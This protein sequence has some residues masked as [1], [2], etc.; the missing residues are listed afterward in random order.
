MGPSV[1]VDRRRGIAL[2]FLLFS[3]GGIWW[4]VLGN[5]EVATDLS[6]SDLLFVALFIVISLGMWQAKE[7]SRWAAGLAGVVSSIR[8]MLMFVSVFVEQAPGSTPPP[9]SWPVFAALLFVLF[10]AGIAV[11][12]LLPST[13]KLFAE[14]RAHAVSR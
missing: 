3:I 5:G 12:C 10:W 9:V 6:W 2:T 1:V 7:W 8:W 4:R 11:Y 14:A 13:G